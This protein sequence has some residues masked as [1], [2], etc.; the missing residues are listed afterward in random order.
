M[1]NKDDLRIQTLTKYRHSGFTVFENPA[2]NKWEI[3]RSKN[4]FGCF[5]TR[6]ECY[7]FIDTKLK[8]VV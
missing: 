4:Y 2:T 6:K 8:D 1:T 7:E 5:D 3:W